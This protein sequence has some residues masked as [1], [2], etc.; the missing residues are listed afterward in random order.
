MNR[1]RFE[2]LV[3]AA[4]ERIPAAFREAMDNVA[5]VID[6]W[7]ER[8]LMFEM[9][10]DAETYIYGL[11]TGTP[12]PEQSMVDSGDLPVVIRIYQAALEYDFAD[13][14]E[15][16]RE[17]EITLVHEIAHFMGFDED[18]LEDLGYD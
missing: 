14:A 12:L 5:I 3:E 11:F 18:E 17:L 10:G 2:E 16:A 7:P 4:L 8:E 15:L 1:K 9:Y 6:D 13:P